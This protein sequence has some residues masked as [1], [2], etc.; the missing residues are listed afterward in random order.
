[1]VNRHDMK[2]LE[3]ICRKMFRFSIVSETATSEIGLKDWSL[4]CELQEF[5]TAYGIFNF[6][7][8]RELEL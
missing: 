4:M 8:R 3:L 2:P 1:M 6:S 7:I 5:R